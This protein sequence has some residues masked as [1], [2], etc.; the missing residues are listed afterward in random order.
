ML[1]PGI[2]SFCTIKKLLC[3]VGVIS[4]CLL[5]SNIRAEDGELSQ[6]SDQGAADFDNNRYFIR[7]KEASFF[8]IKSF[9]NKFMRII[10]NHR[11]D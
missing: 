4:I 10:S 6:S 5:L 11:K 7:L 9:H 8:F 2:N 1:S 3:K